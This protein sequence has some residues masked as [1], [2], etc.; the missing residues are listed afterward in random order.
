M[1]CIQSKPLYQTGVGVKVTKQEED[2]REEEEAKSLN[3]N[4]R[5]HP[6]QDLVN[7]GSIQ[8]HER[9]YWKDFL[10]WKP[11]KSAQG[12]TK[13]GASE[14]PTSTQEQFLFDRIVHGDV[15][16]SLPPEKKSIRIFLSS[17]FNDYAD[18]R[19][20]ILQD[21]LPFLKRFASRF[22]IEII[23]SEMRWGISDA[24]VKENKTIELCLN[25][26]DKCRDE[27]IGPFFCALLGNRYGYCPPPPSLSVEAYNNAHKKAKEDAKGKEIDALVNCYHLDSNFDPPQY[28]LS[29][30]KKKNESFMDKFV[31]FTKFQ[32]DEVFYEALLS[33]FFNS[34]SITE[35]EIAHGFLD[36]SGDSL[37]LSKR[38]AVFHRNLVNLGDPPSPVYF[39]D[40]GGKL[41]ELQ[42]MTRRYAE[43]YKSVF[44]HYNVDSLDESHMKPYLLE[45]SNDF[46]SWVVKSIQQYV[47]SNPSIS[48]GDRKDNNSQI[49]LI[50]EISSHHNQV[51][52]VFVGREN[53]TEKLVS[54][55]TGNKGAIVLRGESGRGK[56][57]VVAQVA[58]IVSEKMN[59]SSK[60]ALLVRFLGTTPSTSTSE[61]VVASML[62]QLMAA[63]PDVAVEVLDGS[64]TSIS[65]SADRFLQLVR[66]LAS[67]DYK[68]CIILDSLDQLDDTDPWRESY[69]QWLPPLFGPGALDNVT[70]LLSALPSHL[71]KI[72]E[73]TFHNIVDLPVF[74]S[75]EGKQMIE[76]LCESHSRRLEEK[77]Q[78]KILTK[79]ERQKSAM[80]L[81]ICFEQSLRWASWHED[82]KVPST[83]DGQL[84]LLF[85]Q[86]GHD[87]GQHLVRSFISHMTI[88]RGGLSQKELRFMVSSDQDVLSEVFKWHSTPDGLVPPLLLARMIYRL[89]PYLVTRKVDNIL[90][91]YWYHRQFWQKAS[92]TYLSD[93]KWVHKVQSQ[94]IKFYLKESTYRHDKTVNERKMRQLPLRLSQLEDWSVL[95]HFLMNNHEALL[96]ELDSEAGLSRYASF[97][98]LLRENSDVEKSLDIEAT[99]IGFST[100]KKFS[101]EQIL[102]I[103]DFLKKYFNAY[104][105]A[106]Q[107]YQTASYNLGITESQHFDCMSRIGDVYTR[108]S[109]YQE[110]YNWLSKSYTG[111]T[112][113]D[114]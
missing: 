80:F 112:R 98:R 18:E 42:L 79:F 54:F 41:E 25:E 13:E 100:E 21:S 66:A 59:R 63:F 44:H 78:N 48:S 30:H 99:L 113:Y 9:E 15:T 49:N 93:R 106:L 77:Q 111:L 31:A 34:I 94:A 22:G 110:G 56:T 86:L 20:F 39:D 19:N 51:Q 16:A 46:C 107:V 24:A 6:S 50:R 12:G 45:F 92:S 96:I 83:V 109:D 1:G 52:R 69:D 28:I 87:F 26:I 33:S 2:E 11:D 108:L 82:I 27:S 32:E 73:M 3:F 97:W 36:P 64:D 37:L 88:A 47:S 4:W 23:I 60:H 29:Y 103:G 61:A 76:K 104:D 114:T 40:N 58:K 75:E 102:Q 90:T 65:N 62:M 84:S 72:E 74:T 91:L 8:R 85:R 35:R 101:F 57:S 105:A 95:H 14:Q 68:I 70:I 53:I 89:D 38:I 67:R 43:K 55:C 10:Y 71:G 17:T 5:H 81:K 7:D